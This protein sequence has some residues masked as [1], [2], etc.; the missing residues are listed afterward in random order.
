[1]TNPIH[2]RTRRVTTQPSELA[3]AVPQV[4]AHR[5]ARIVTSGAN[6]NSRDRREFQRMSQEKIAALLRNRSS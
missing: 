1:M 4:A 6:P 2:R 3:F 5:V